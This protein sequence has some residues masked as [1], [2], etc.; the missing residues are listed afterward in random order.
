VAKPLCNTSTPEPPLR[1]SRARLVLPLALLLAAGLLPGLPSLSSSAAPDAQPGML[2]GSAAVDATWHVGASQGQYAG[3][4][5]GVHDLE[6]GTEDP[7]VHATTSNP[8]HGIESRDT[9]RALV[10]QGAAGNRWALVTND[11]YIPQDLV[12]QRVAGLLAEHDLLHPEAPTGITPDNLTVSVSHSHSSPFYSSTTWG[13]WAFQDV[14][15]LRFFEFMARKMAD[16]VIEATTGLRPARAAAATIPVALTKRNPEGP[17]RSHEDE[18]LPAGWSR[19]DTD[20]T[21]TLL[22]VDDL[23]RATPAPMASWLVFGRHPEGMQDNGLHTGEYV[24]NLLRAVDRKLGGV[25]LFSQNDTGSSEIA[26]ETNAHSAVARQEYDENSHNM[27]ERMANDLAEAV[28][29][30][31]ADIDRA[32]AATGA[33]G[34]KA[35]GHDKGKARG[36]ADGHDRDGTAVAPVTASQVELINRQA[37]VEVTTERFA[38]PSYRLFPSVSNCRTETAAHGNPQAPLVGVPNCTGTGQNVFAPSPVDPGVAYDTLREAGVPIPDN[39]GAPSYTG[40]QESTHVPLQ[41]VRLGDV[42]IVVCPCEMFTDQAR[43]TRSRLDKVDGNLWFGF[44]WTANPRFSPSFQPGVAYVGDLLPGAALGEGVRRGPAQLDIDPATPGDQLWCEPD[45]ATAPTTWTCK[46]PEAIPSGVDTPM[47]A[48]SSFPTLPPVS[49]EAFVRW[50]ARMYNDAA[51]WDGY[52]GEDGSPDALKAESEPVNPLEIWGNWTQEEQTEHGYAMV[53]TVSMSNDY[54]GYI[55]TYREF[56]NRD[57][58][59]KA[60]AG[61][62]PHSSDFF[63]TRLTRMAASLNGGAPVELTAKDLAYSPEEAH[64]TV[65]AAAIGNAAAAYLPVYEAGLPA[66]AGTPGTVVEQPRSVTRF[67]TTSFRW[68][69][70]SNY[71]DTPHA[72]VE[73]QDASGAW[74]PFGDGYG[75]V[76]VRAKMPTAADLPLVAAGQYPWVWTATFE[77]Y[78]SDI[79]RAFADGGERAQVPDGTYRFVVDGCARGLVPDGAPDEG[80]SEWD[81]TGRVQPYTATSQPFRVTPWEGLTVGAPVVSADGTSVS[82]DVGPDLT[83]A[84]LSASNS[85]LQVFTSSAGQVDRKPLTYSY[86]RYDYALRD[87]AVYPSSMEDSGRTHPMR[88]IDKRAAD[89]T[90]TYSGLVERYCFQCSFEPWADTAAVESVFLTVQRLAGGTERVPAVFDAASRRWVAQVALGL[91]DRVQVAAGDVRD[92]FGERNGAPSPVV[93]R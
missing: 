17:G 10:V 11:L 22:R 23:S 7:Y 79:D 65:K 46:N 50:K 51:G 13:A 34:G 70:G 19:E 30:G 75:E 57:Y 35:K 59:R 67:D 93:T 91:G 26:K 89:D 84:P 39:Y 92:T 76:Q 66:D 82:V 74:Q 15:D 33:P 60:L 58:Y 72:R 40:L 38:P 56:Q 36:D 52:I 62:G 25:T 78:D 48:W 14:F 64:T 18:P 80:C 28:A 20:G 90:K 86:G 61:L 71:A 63:A 77:A 1:F 55:P 69:G 16:A 43:N 45:S 27:L 9:V 24:G 88:Y 42:A 6:E 83:A 21:L 4:G 5:P 49:H 44:D 29:G 3:E 8:T 37:P 41:A 31:S 53:V 2:A 54:W 12:N 81:A 32:Y 85:A 87:G 73:R 47:P 68:V